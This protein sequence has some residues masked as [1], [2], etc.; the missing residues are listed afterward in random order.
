M[1]LMGFGCKEELEGDVGGRG[2][3]VQQR[4]RL[5]VRADFG[6]Q[7]SNALFC[8]VLD[9]EVAETEEEWCSRCSL[10]SR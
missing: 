2:R 4:V 10:Y 8:G 9:V 7:M 3:V 5:V 1:A 6:A